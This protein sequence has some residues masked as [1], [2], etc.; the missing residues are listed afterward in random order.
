MGMVL[1]I[2][3]VIFAAIAIME[4]K[5]K[6]FAAWGVLMLAL[7]HLLALFGQLPK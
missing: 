1:V 6:A 3:A 5:G 2:L 7:L 4:S